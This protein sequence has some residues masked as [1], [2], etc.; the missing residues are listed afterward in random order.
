MAKLCWAVEDLPHLTK[1][2]YAPEEEEK[3]RVGARQRGKQ[4]KELTTQR[5][6]SI[7]L[8]EP[9]ASIF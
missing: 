9:Q 7:H 3:L 1:G 6:S 2:M 4:G 8:Q 5:E